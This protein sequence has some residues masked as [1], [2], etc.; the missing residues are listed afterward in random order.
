VEFGCHK[1]VIKARALFFI[2]FLF[3]KEAV[4]K[5]GKNNLKLNQK[6]QYW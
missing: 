2:F 3:V 5:T 6:L 1:V 4:D